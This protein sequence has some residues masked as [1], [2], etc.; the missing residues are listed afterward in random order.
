MQQDLIETFLDLCDTQSFNQTAERLGITQ[1][2]VSGRV[3]TLERQLECR[4]FTRS[5]AGTALTTEGLRFEPHARTLRHGWTEAR[6]A[7]RDA[8]DP[9]LALRIGIQHDLMGD[10][11]AVWLGLIRA[12]LPDAALYVESDFSTQM[13]TDV[14]RGEL[15]IA[16]AFTPKPHPDLHF[17]TMGEVSYRMVSTDTDQLSAVRVENYILPNYSPAFAQTHAALFPKLSTAPVSS[18]Q[19]AVV[20]SLLGAFGGGT[21]LPAKTAARRAEAGTLYTVRRASPIRQPVSAVLHLRNR[22]R[23]PHR[24]IIRLL[25]DELSR[26]EA[27]VARD[28]PAHHR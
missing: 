7:V 2:T 12:A 4:L 8:R 15:D 20:E 14:T 16:F 13:C 19:T 22:H 11:V 23:G 21:F 18:G 28:F 17:E 3:R 6:H 27:L 10:R 24:R 9:G 26:S 5:R 25:S 1:S